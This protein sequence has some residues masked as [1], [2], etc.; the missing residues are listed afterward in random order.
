VL[1]P[2]FV[3]GTVFFVCQRGRRGVC[4]KYSGTKLENFGRLEIFKSGDLSD[5]ADM[6]SEKK[7]QR[8][9]ISAAGGTRLRVRE[10]EVGFVE[11]RGGGEEG[12]PLIIFFI[13]IC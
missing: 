8:R 11:R 1:L 13:E 3:L 5:R 10:K 4:R 6:Y 2:F 12:G 9:Y 7:D